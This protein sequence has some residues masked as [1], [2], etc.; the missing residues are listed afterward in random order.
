MNAVKAAIERCGVVGILR[1]AANV[2]LP[3]V[4]GALCRGGLSVL[5]ITLNT[6]GALKAIT[7]IRQQMAAEMTL[8]AGTIL[9]PADAEGAIAAGAQFIVTPTLQLD[10]IAL[11]NRRQV[12]II[13]GALTPTEMLAAHR[14]GADYV[15]LFPANSF[16]LEYIKAVMAPM[17]FL[18]IVP[19][20]GVTLQ[21]VASFLAAGLPA[22]A[23][24]SSITDPHL[25]AGGKWDELTALARQFAEAAQRGLAAAKAREA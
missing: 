8:G 13:C 20:G 18:R 15:K 19:T 5:E 23:I 7:Q 10:T 12:P 14:G 24:G 16:G 17:P 6:P 4:C 2:D 3:A 25:I 22:V 11:C 9:G 1:C 21:N